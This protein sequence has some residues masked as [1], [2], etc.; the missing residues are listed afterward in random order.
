MKFSHFIIIA[1]SILSSAFLYSCGDTDAIGTSLMQTE[2][3]III[4]DGFNL[5]G[6]SVENNKVQSRTSMLL[7]GSFDAEGYGHFK[8]D[9]VTQ[10]MPVAHIDSTLTSATAIDSVKLKMMFAP[11][12]FVGDSIIPMGLE[13]FRL[14]EDLKAPIF[15]DF[16]PS[17][18][19]DASNIIGS[20]VYDASNLE[21]S[22][23]LKQ[24]D[25]RDIYVDL[26]LELGTELFNLYKSSPQIYNDPQAFAKEFPGLYVRNSYGSGR[27]TQIGA[28][29]LQLYY[30]YNT[31]NTEGNDTTYNYIGNFYSATP[32]VLSNNNIDYEI[33]QIL[34]DKVAQG[35]QLIVA[36]A[37]LDVEMEFPL[38]D[39]INFY[40]QN[41]GHLSVINN[42]TLSIPAID[43]SNEYGID[44]PTQLLMVL[45]KDKDKFFENSEVTDGITSFY[46]EFSE[47]TDTYDFSS[48]RSYLL[49][50]MKR[51]AELTP[52]DFTFI[53][54]AVTVD[55]ET[56]YDS[57][58]GAYSNYVKAIVP[59]VQQ[60]AMARLNLEKAKIILT[61][62]DQRIN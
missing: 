14:T 35:Q 48:L 61:F 26:P 18:Y 32:E 21:L 12:N 37:G 51:E 4:E 19:F 47:D 49:D 6:H 15:S 27:V 30:H 39:V 45:K 41:S 29:M 58:S 11:G 3:T 13:V 60:P 50:A 55:A 59:Y 8:S 34:K 5:T 20:T 38:L 24:L 7:I 46:A 36:P 31:I 33:S 57:Y 28:A 54:T 10:F 42:L 1:T 22:D 25:H 43:I 2:N 52:D 44:P 16:D 17:S 40:R 62:T 53:L 9:F 23:S 56:V